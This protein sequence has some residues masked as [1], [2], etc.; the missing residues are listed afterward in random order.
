MALKHLTR[1]KLPRPNG[2]EMVVYIGDDGY[3]VEALNRFDR[4]LDTRGNRPE[5]RDRYLAAAGRF[6]DY[7]IE[8]GAYG[9]PAR[10]SI[11]AE[12]IDA[13][14]VFLRDG[15]RI[16]WPALPTL[17][18]YAGEIGFERGLAYNSMTPVIAAVNHFLRLARDHALRTADSLRDRTIVA[19]WLDLQVTFAAIEGT[20]AWSRE[21]QARLKQGTM[22]GGVTRLRDKLEKPRG[23]RSAVK[24]GVQVDLE[25]KEFPFSRLGDLLAQA[26]THRDRALWA[27]LAG[28]GLRI[29]EALNL[30]MRHFD[31]T[32]GEI[33]VLDREKEW[34]DSDLTERERLRFKGRTIARVYM[35][36]PLRSVFWDAL[37]S[38]LLTEYV[39][40]AGNDDFL[41]KKLDGSGRGRPLVEASD[42]AVGK[43]FKAA[44]VRAGVPGPPE[45]PAHVWTLHSLRH[46]YGVYMLNHIPVPGGPGLRLT[47]VQMLMG[48]ARVSSTQV[49]AR[50]D[51]I[52]LEAQVEAANAVLFSGQSKDVQETMALLPS[53]IATRLRAT[54]DAIER[55]GRSSAEA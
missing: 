51:M 24:G 12:A 34:A 19:D 29:S 46:S 16:D 6:V 52:L 42:T 26:R 32:T 8:C 1:M 15:A 23:L 37:R 4:H 48:H 20:Q 36:E 44:V 21:E 38:Y 9:V 35:Y 50:H 54:A 28:G 2:K 25:H 3:E 5:T 31:A 27:L 22:M 47:E 40:S 39:G 30:G 53:S 18:E 49:Y 41:F 14:P 13:Y 43:A 10:P 55:S 7:L 45:A 17:G 11:I 33:W